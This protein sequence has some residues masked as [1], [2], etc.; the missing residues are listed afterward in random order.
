[1]RVKIFTALLMQWHNNANKRELPWKGE[2]DPYKIWISEIILQQTRSKQGRSYYEK[3]INKYP[4]IQRLAKA[5][6]EEVYKVW[7]GLGYYNR[8]KNL[9][10]SA[11]FICAEHKGTFPSEYKKLLELKGV[12]PY[13]AAAISSFAYNLPYAVVD[14]NVYRVLSRVYG[15]DLPIDS[16][17]GKQKFQMLAN[18]VLDKNNPAA[19]NQAIMDFGATICKPALPLCSQCYLQKFCVAY[20]KALVNKLPVK[21]KSI[22][23]K[24]RWFTYFLFEADNYVLVKQRSGKDIWENLYEFYLMETESKPLWNKEKI[25]TLLYNQF[26]LKKTSEEYISPF[27]SQQ[28][29]HQ[30][31]QGQ[32]IKIKVLEIP[33]ILQNNQWINIK[34]LNK[35]AFPKLINQYLQSKIFNADIF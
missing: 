29:T 5:N 7:E 14:G 20:N 11:R 28:L 3:F 24:L 34:N 25:N 22:V 10:I 21:E 31:I 9:L 33:A 17:Y 6:D 23:K 30:N 8:C 35:L 13:T 12:G 26:K 16:I 1:M 15:I 32:F 4:T 18:K 19:F 27:F 2:K